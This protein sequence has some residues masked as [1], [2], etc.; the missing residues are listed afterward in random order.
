[1]QAKDEDMAGQQALREGAGAQADACKRQR[2]SQTVTRQK[3]YNQ[4]EEKCADCF[5]FT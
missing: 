5:V 2:P 1:M 4:D 3:M